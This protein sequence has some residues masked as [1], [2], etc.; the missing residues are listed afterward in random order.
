MKLKEN[1]VEYINKEEKFAFYIFYS[2][3][4]L[5]EILFLCRQMWK[6]KSTQQHF[7]KHM[8]LLM[9]ISFCLMLVTE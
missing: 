1:S 3:K 9:L 2:D 7:A 4:S 8:I 6:L 5:Y